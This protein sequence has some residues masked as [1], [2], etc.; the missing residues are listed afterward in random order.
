[1]LIGQPIMPPPQ[2][3]D[4]VFFNGTIKLIAEIYGDL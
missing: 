4:K 2:L 1:M 3:Y